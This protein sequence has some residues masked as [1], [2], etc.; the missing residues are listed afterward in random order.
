MPSLLVG[1]CSVRSDK[2]LC[3]EHVIKCFCDPQRIIGN[4][5][6]T[7]TSFNNQ[8]SNYIATHDCML[9]TGDRMLNVIKPLGR[10]PL[11]TSGR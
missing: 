1:E 4:R 6:V 11:E 7:I 5:S 2:F 3:V 8:K 9:L 10:T